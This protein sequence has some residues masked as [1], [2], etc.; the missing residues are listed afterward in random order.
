MARARP[1]ARKP[2]V[3]P[4]RFFDTARE[5]RAWLSRHHT[6]ARELLVGFRR[7]SVEEAG[8]TW[9]EAVD[10][11]LCFGWVDGVRRRIDA[12]SYA[13]RFT[14]RRPGS[15]WSAVNIARADELR[16]RSLMKPAGLAAFRARSEQAS[17]TYSYERTSEARLAGELERRLKADRRLWTFHEEQAPSYR[18]KVVHWIM[19]AKADEARERR[20]SR[21]LAAYARGVRL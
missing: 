10:Q 6:S 3:S 13:I 14:P 18:R 4:P 12:T 21:L 9:Q 19:S 17:R 7:R 11:A 5:L 1:T 2:S 8:I 16:S 15:T 20:L